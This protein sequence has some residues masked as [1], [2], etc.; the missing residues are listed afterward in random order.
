MPAALL[1]SDD[2]VLPSFAASGS[3]LAWLLCLCHQGAQLPAEA[4]TTAAQCNSL[5]CRMQPSMQSW[6]LQWCQHSLWQCMTEQ[7]AR[8]GWHECVSSNCK[9]PRASLLCAAYQILCHLTRRCCMQLATACTTPAIAMHT[10][11]DLPICLAVYSS[12][13]TA[14]TA[15]AVAVL[16]S[17]DLP[18]WP[19][20]RRSPAKGA[21]ACGRGTPCSAASMCSTGFWRRRMP[22]P[23]AS[24]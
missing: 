13:V 19:A 6:A 5:S 1:A 9:L 7:H 23:S 24:R 11:G 15:S 14:C 22:N 2:A 17:E 12:P 21:A 3:L 8:T 18:S 20:L 16:V 4:D 10:S